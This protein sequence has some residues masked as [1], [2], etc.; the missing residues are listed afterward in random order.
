MTLWQIVVAGCCN[1]DPAHNAAID[2]KIA[3][4]L[5]LYK[6]AIENEMYG[7]SN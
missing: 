1:S 3:Q 2:L 5:D 4:F 7:F 6:T